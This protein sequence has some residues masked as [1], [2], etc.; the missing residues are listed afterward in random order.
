MSRPI[1]YQ[2]KILDNQDPMMLGRVRATL[3]IDNYEDIVKRYWKLERNKKMDR[4]W[5]IYF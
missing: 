5:P 3:L 1:F 2:V 4:R